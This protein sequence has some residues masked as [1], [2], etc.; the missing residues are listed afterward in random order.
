MSFKNKRKIF[1][2]CNT[3][4]DNNKSSRRVLE[5]VKSM[6]GKIR[7]LA[8]R[9]SNTNSILPVPL[10]SSKITSSILEPVSTRAVA[11]M[12]SDPPFSI[13]RAAPKNCFG[14]CI[15][16]ASTPPDNTLPELGATVLCARAKRV[17]ESNKITTSCPHSTKRFAFC[18]AT[19]ETLTCFSAGSS[20]VEAMTS[21]FTERS[22]S[23][24]SSGLSSINNI[25]K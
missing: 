16:L 11:M 17:I 24:T 4:A 8:N 15:A 22:T 23:V 25:I 18:N 5:P 20:K 10:N 19:E 3:S 2:L 14:F 6:A 7:L 1:I 12:V 9:R 13:L 21:P